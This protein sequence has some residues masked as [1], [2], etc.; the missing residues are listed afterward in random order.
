MRNPGLMRNYPVT[1]YYLPFTLVRVLVSLALSA[2]TY[3]VS[4]RKAAP[5]KRLMLFC[6][7]LNKY[8]K[9]LPIYVFQSCVFFMRRT[10]VCKTKIGRPP[11]IVG[12]LSDSKKE[13]VLRK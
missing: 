8:E 6:Q 2:I 9:L 7:S 1:S 10:Q 3:E 4:L 11:K 13:E 5:L 12:N